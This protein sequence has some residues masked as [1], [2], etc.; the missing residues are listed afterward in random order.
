MTFLLGSYLE[1]KLE[2]WL[3]KASCVIEWQSTGTTGCPLVL[4]S[5]LLW[6][7]SKWA[8]MLSCAT[9]CREPALAGGWTQWS[10]LRSPSQRSLAIPAILEFCDFV[11]CWDQDPAYNY[12]NPKHVF[13]QKRWS[14]QPELLHPL[15]RNIF[16][17]KKRCCLHYKIFSAN[18]ILNFLFLCY[19]LHTRTNLYQI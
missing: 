1:M 10:P 9:Y 19:I 12:D 18:M 4:W 2:T 5:F 3:C 11:M 15:Q 7:Y 17:S 13:I 14:C 6:R 8:W 16:L